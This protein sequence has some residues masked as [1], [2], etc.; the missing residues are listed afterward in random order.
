[1]MRSLTS[2]ASVFREEVILSRCE[3]DSRRSYIFLKIFFSGSTGP[4]PI[5]PPDLCYVLPIVS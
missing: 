2:R 1:V 4:G 5:L 3:F